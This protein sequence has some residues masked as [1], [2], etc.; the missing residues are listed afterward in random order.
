[1]IAPRIEETED[2]SQTLRHPLLNETYHSSRGAVGEAEHVFIRAGL[3]GWIE[4]HGGEFT[5]GYPSRLTTFPL[6]G[7]KVRILE[8]GFG[9]GLNAWLT[10]RRAQEWGLEVEYYG[11]ELYP[12][13]WEVAAGLRYASD[14]LFEALHRASWS[15]MVS[16]T[17]NFSLRKEAASLLDSSFLTTFDLIYYDAFAPETQPELWSAELFI[18]LFDAMNAGGVWVTYSA[19]GEVKRNLRA[20]GFEVER[21]PGALGKRHMLRAI[22]PSEG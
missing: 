10:A 16:I 1:M 20:A 14:P 21:L 11:W 8:M 7:R 12:V 6:S 3:R 18:R 19:K 13:S 22:K 15:E 9:S 4:R 17:E 5:D 2:G